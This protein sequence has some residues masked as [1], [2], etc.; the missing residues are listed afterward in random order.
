LINIGH[1]D[2]LL[3][4]ADIRAYYHATYPVEE[5]ALDMPGVLR[6]LRRAAARAQRI[7]VDIDCD[8][9]DP[10]F[11]SAVAQPLPFGLNPQQVLAVLNAIWSKRVIGVSLSEFEPGR[12]QG[13]RS[14]A[15]VMWLL[16]NLLLKRCGQ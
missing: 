8:V 4:A 7:W 5:F 3:L 13:D 10:A 11:F 2:Q 12:D 6:R 14:L 1:R 16:E 15:I 9:F